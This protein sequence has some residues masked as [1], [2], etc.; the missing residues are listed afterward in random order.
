METNQFDAVIVGAGF[1]GL[2]SIHRL[3]A[4]GLSVQC[5]EAADGVGGTWYWNRYP[6]ARCDVESLNYSYSFSEELQ[7]E[8]H[9][10]ER[11]A[12]Q[13]DILE[14]IEHVAARFDLKRHIRFNTRVDAARFDDAR[15]RWQVT[16]AD[17]SH[18]SA[19][20]VI[21]ATGCLSLPR[22]PDFPGLD[23]F[24]GQW[25]HTGQWPH[26]A[27]D[28]TGQR[29]GVIGTGSSG[30]QCIPV[31]AQQAAHLTV[32]QRTP[33]Y[34]VPARN[35]PLNP[36][37]EADIKSRYA[38]YREAARDTPSGV[39]R[40]KQIVASVFDVADAEREAAFER[41]WAQGGTGF[42]RAYGDTGQ[43]I[44]ANTVVADFVRKKIR[45]VV[46]DP[47]V[48]ALLT[49]QD[50]PIGTKRLCLDTDYYATYNRPNVTLVD[51]RSAPIERLVPEGLRT[52]AATYP[53][54]SIVFAIGYD[55]ITGALNHIDVR[56]RDGQSLRAKWAAG[57]RAHL[58]L[59]SAGFPNFFMITGPGSPS[60]LTN[61]MVSIE[62][63]VD[64]IA[65]CI[66]TLGA[67]G[68]ATLEPE[69]GAEDQW[70]AQLNEIASR[71]LHGRANSWYRG[72]NV[73]GKPQVFMPYAG[74]LHTYRKLCEDIVG[75]G[76]P[77]FRFGG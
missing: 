47:Q 10:R 68:S 30:V 12:S 26:H 60:V 65:T 72:V 56:G 39:L 21:M 5:I 19:R 50:Y 15:Q 35:G 71:T 61:M 17:G 64:F 27:V 4:M 23:D 42:T 45:E 6:G 8:W 36:A 44:E 63:H 69:T 51:V 58:G 55:A 37:H 2:Y 33:P 77:G 74:G 67:R 62:Q 41:L 38:A 20:F 57:P 76:F 29:V 43:T 48:A 13:A 66:G 53:L 25:Y 7:Q 59:M 49:A 14:Y 46:R 32:F 54:D 70:V 75:Q 52:S 9:W 24:R 3:R 11:Y 22:K 16:C 31:I 34:S 28:F 40:D 1:A 73:P 18:Y